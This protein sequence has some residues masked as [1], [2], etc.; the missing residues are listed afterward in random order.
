MNDTPQTQE[1][2]HIVFEWQILQPITVNP[3]L[4]G[5]RGKHIT[6]LT[7]SMTGDSRG[8]GEEHSEGEAVNVKK[9][10][11]LELVNPNSLSQ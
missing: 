9:V 3:P 6:T 11:S 2:T 1:A 10:A 5:L 8:D 4:R 7:S